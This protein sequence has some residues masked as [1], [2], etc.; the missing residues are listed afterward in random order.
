MDPVPQRGNMT[1][2]QINHDEELALHLYIQQAEDLARLIRLVSGGQLNLTVT[3]NRHVAPSLKDRAAVVGDWDE[4]HS[5][6]SKLG[7]GSV[8]Q[9]EFTAGIM[10][11]RAATN[12]APA[13]G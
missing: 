2:A 6:A 5:Q 4:A 12:Q 1:M 11:Y 7:D 13:D 9:D 3:H 8:S 10:A